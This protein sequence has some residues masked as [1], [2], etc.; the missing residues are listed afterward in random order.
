MYETGIYT[1]QQVI[2]NLNAEA[3]FL[4]AE[5]NIKK[6]LQIFAKI[7]EIITREPNA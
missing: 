5:D 3:H 2:R 6:R 1:R 4:L 7:N